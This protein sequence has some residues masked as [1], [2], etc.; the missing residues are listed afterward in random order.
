MEDPPQPQYTP[1]GENILEKD[2]LDLRP[3]ILE[4]P[5]KSEKRNLEDENQFLKFP[6]IKETYE[7]NIYPLID[8]IIG[9]TNSYIFEQQN[10][11]IKQRDRDP[12]R[13]IF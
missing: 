8:G 13:K 9:E 7:K 5:P 4:F 12:F 10:I 3:V 11:K 1:S 6:D 2:Q